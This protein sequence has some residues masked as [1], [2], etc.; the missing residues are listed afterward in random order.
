MKK[1]LKKINKLSILG[2]IS[3]IILFFI[4]FIVIFAPFISGYSYKIPSG[5]A[6][7][8]PSF[9]HILGTDDLGIDLWSQICNGARI[10]VFIGSITAIFAGGFGSIIGILSGYYGGVLDKIIMRVTDTMIVLPDLPSMIVI[11]AF[12]GTSLK[13]IIIVL[14]LFLWT[15]PARVIRSKIISLKE[16]RFIIAARSYGDNFIGITIR[17]F[18]PHTMPL[19]GLNVMKLMSKAII[20][21]TSLAFLGI[22]DPTSKSWGLI[23]YHAINFNGIYFTPYWKWWV[24]VPIIS[25]ISLVLALA[26]LLR[27]I[28]KIIDTKI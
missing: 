17:H 21:E 25:I 14:S 5:K 22:G 26:M 16:E 13:N 15:I 11:G 28:E 20:A 19:I 2:K 3:L 1:L 12:F 24:V 8:A 9:V 6:L 27:D 23:L 18:L 7:E 10:S 4:M